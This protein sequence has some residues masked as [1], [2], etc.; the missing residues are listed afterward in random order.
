MP[1]RL[2]RLRNLVTANIVGILWS[3]AMFAWF[4]LSALYMQMVLE[5]TALQ[6][7]LAFL[8]SN[9]IMGAFSLGL[10][11]KVVMRFGIRWPLAL[12]LALVA[13]GLG[14]FALA[15]V[16]G[17]FVSMC[18]PAWCSSASAWASPSTRCSSPR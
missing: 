15:P 18:F 11:A 16:D 10:S 6:V 2:F 12:G 5:Y 14:A 1:L 7:G 13:L 4:F 3:T 9:I 17:Q 8:P